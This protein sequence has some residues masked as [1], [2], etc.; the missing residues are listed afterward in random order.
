MLLNIS[1]MPSKYGKFNPFEIFLS[2]RNID[3]FL[4]LYIFLSR[5]N[6]FERKKNVIIRLINLALLENC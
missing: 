1:D 2:S 5:K 6:K 3:V 4:K